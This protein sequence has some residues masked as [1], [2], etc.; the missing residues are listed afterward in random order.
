M[1]ESYLHF[2]WKL[3][4]LP[5][6]RLQTTNGKKIIIFRE[7]H[8]NLSESGPDFF[9]AHIFYED[10]QWVGQIEIHVKSSDWYL[11]GHHLDCAYSNV[12]LHVV[13]EH[14]KEV[15]LNGVFLPTVELKSY[16]ESSH[17]ANWQ[18]LSNSKH[19]IP[20]NNFLFS[21]D[22]IFLRAM[23]HRV[24]IER[25]NRKAKE[26][27]RLYHQMMHS[28]FLYY[29]VAKAFG[30]KTNAL[31]FELLTHRVPLSLLKSH[32]YRKQRELLLC[33]SGV[34][35]DIQT[36]TN[37][38]MKILPLSSALWKHKGIRPSAFPKKR[39]LQFSELITQCDIDLLASYDSPQQAQPTIRKV[40]DRVNRQ[41]EVFIS[42]KLIDLLFINALV[43]YYWIKSFHTQDEAVRENILNF[44]ET[45][46]PEENNILKKWKSIGVRAKSA[47]ESQGLIEL[48]TQYCTHKKCLT[49]QVGAKILNK[50]KKT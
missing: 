43:P 37:K 22:P 11:H 35:R 7:G 48:Y 42:N 13:Y 41:Q 29:L 39:V 50:S 27:F 40:V 1:T 21:I 34:Y 23:I 44:L 9:N 38:S 12:I 33:A 17:Y 19:F 20:C 46:K 45:I 15:E 2:L 30:T 25:L 26:L 10:L 24:V 36:Q 4:R 49:C 16:I 6:H 28:E 47:Y 18:V 14:D 5:F 8:H 3:K 31:P 32:S